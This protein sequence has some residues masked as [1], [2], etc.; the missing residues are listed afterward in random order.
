MAQFRINLTGV[1]HEEWHQ[2]PDLV[3]GGHSQFVDGEPSCRRW[4]ADRLDLERG[5]GSR[6]ARARHARNEVVDDG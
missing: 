4:L 1:V 6:I 5:G 2:F 3:Q